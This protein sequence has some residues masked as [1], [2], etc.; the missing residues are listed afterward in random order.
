MEVVLAPTVTAVVADGPALQQA[1]INLAVNAR[2]AMPEGGRLRIETAD[3]VLGADFVA[4]HRG[5]EVGP[6]VMIAVSDTGTGMDEAVKAHAF[7]PFFTTKPR[8]KGTGLGLSSVYAAVK[9][10]HGSISID[11]AP[12]RGSTFRLY[13]PASTVAAPVAVDAEPETGPAG[14]EAIL[15]VED[16]D[17]VRELVQAVLS[18]KG[19]AVTA[20][21]NPKEG[22]EILAGHPRFDMLL[23][24]VTMPGMDGRE[25]AE[26]CQAQRPDLRVLFM[27]GHV[28]VLVDDNG[29]LDPGLAV[30]QKPFAGPVLLARIRAILDAPSAASG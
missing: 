29:V 26:R 1:L 20:A 22:L 3:V 21:A 2:D 7:E 6:H 27:T 28:D 11:S 25:F 18:R 13:L 23:T 17:A 16:D 4:L 30:I 19:Y 15:L 10:S 12:G 8:G 5:S 24:D 9:Q 14:S